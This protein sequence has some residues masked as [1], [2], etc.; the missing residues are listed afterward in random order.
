MAFSWP[1]AFRSRQAQHLASI[2]CQ[3]YA[4]S[5]LKQRHSLFSSH[6]N[7]VKRYHNR[8]GKSQKRTKTERNFRSG[9]EGMFQRNSAPEAHGKKFCNC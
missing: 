5:S 8:H 9:I 6:E 7:V 2:T 3:Q 1:I 4:I